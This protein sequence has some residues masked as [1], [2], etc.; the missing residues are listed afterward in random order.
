MNAGS[1]ETQWMKAA[2]PVKVQESQEEN[3]VNSYTENGRQSDNKL[4]KDWESVVPG[5]LAPSHLIVA[6]I[7]CMRNKGYCVE[8]AEKYIEEGSELISAPLCAR[9]S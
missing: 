7:Q 3:W 9:M 8:E 1:R 5:S 2:F 4:F 6:A